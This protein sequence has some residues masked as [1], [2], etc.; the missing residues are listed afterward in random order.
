MKHCKK[1]Y[2][3]PPVILREVAF[4]PERGLLASSVVD[5]ANIRSVGQEV[6][7]QD[8]STGDFNHDWE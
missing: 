6:E 4:R 7:E 2:Y 5:N 8:W 1:N 3:E